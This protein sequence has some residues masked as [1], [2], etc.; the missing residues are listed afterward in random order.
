[1][2]IDKLFNEAKIFCE[3]NKYRFTEPRKNVLK[4]ILNS[5]EPLTAYDMLRE[6]SKN[7]DRN[8][9][10]IYRAIDFWCKHSFIHRIETLGSYIACESKH[11]HIGVELCVCDKCGTVKEIPIKLNIIKELQET[12]AFKVRSWNLE[13]RGI[14]SNCE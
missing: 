5:D 13:I 10:T 14:C 4:L 3:Q 11:Q 1:M 12:V 7:K 6:L 9:P 2:N 8:P